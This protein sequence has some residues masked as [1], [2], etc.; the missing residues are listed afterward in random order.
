M[1]F[2]PDRRAFGLECVR[3]TVSKARVELG[4]EPLETR[5]GVP[6]RAEPF[7]AG[8]RQIFP[9][10]VVKA[11]GLL[12]DEGSLVHRAAGDLVALQAPRIRST[13]CRGVGP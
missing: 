10:G 11:C 5:L 9:A 12:H 2:S 1:N 4:Y 8:E 13:N 7:D 6:H 3:V